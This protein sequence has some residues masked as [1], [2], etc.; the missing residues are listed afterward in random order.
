MQQLGAFSL[1]AGVG[2]HRALLRLGVPTKLKWPNDVLLRGRKLAG[3]LIEADGEAEGPVRIV[4]GI[5]I[6]HQLFGA[7]PVDAASVGPAID[8][9]ELAIAVLEELDRAIESFFADGFACVAHEFHAADA[10]RDRWL[11]IDRGTDEVR[12]VGAGVDAEGRLLLRD[13]D[14]LHRLTTGSII[15]YAAD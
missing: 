6:N 10:L 13:G 14:H 8:R 4:T 11:R 1:V 5:G 9:N 12:G 3:V 2:V 7:E 15:E